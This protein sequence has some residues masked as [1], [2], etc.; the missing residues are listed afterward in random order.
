MNNRDYYENLTTA[1]LKQECIRKCKDSGQ[2][3]SWV[4]TTSNE[5]RIQFLL[6]NEQPTDD[7]LP[8]SLP[9]MQEHNADTSTDTAS[10]P[11]V[12]PQAG[13]MESMIVDAVSDKIKNEVTDEVMTLAVGLEERVQ[14]MI[15]TAE[16]MVKPITIEVKDKPT[17][18]ITDE[19]VHPKFDEVFESLYYKNLVCLVGPAGTGKSTLVKQVWDKLAPSIDMSVND[20]QYIGCSVGLSE[21]QLLG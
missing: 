2:K 6:G 10:K 11:N 20:Y 1:E 17:I 18:T 19:M 7:S 16:D 13:S 4:Q 21:A 8:T 9:K 5:K 15:S 12:Q 14:D 3:S